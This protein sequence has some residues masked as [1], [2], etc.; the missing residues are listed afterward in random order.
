MH[1]RTSSPTRSAGYGLQTPAVAELPEQRGR[2]PLPDT[3]SQAW[4]RR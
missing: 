1:A 2:Q 3:H 4:L